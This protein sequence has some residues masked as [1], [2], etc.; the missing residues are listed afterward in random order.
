LAK[1]ASIGLENLSN[2]ATIPVRR[3]IWIGLPDAQGCGVGSSEYRRYHNLV[4]DFRSFQ[5]MKELGWPVVFDATHSVQR[6]AGAGKASSGDRKFIPVLCRAAVAAGVDGLFLETHP[7]PEKA[8]SDG[9]NSWPLAQ[10]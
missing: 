4:V 5:I 9:P 7:A 6:P 3:K 1:G 8:L 10:I 2:Y